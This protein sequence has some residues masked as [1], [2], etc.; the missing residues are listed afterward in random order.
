MRGIA[1]PPEL[2][3]RKRRGGERDVHA[4]IGQGLRAPH[5][6]HGGAPAARET[7][8]QQSAR[9]AAQCPCIHP[10]AAPDREGFVAIFT[11]KILG[12]AMPSSQHQKRAAHHEWDADRPVLCHFTCSAAAQACIGQHAASPAGLIAERATAEGYS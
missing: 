5:T 2:A 4:H 10:V 3:E 1:R 12:P 6:Q 7:G 11:P 8:Q 9:V